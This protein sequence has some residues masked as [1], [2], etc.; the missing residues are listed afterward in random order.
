MNILG[1]KIDGHDTGAALI[2]G[3]KVIAIA[4]ER[5]MRVKHAPWTFPEKA[6]DYCLNAAGISADDLDLVVLDS[7]SKVVG[8]TWAQ[9]FHEKT[10]N[11][12]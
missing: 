9:I 5:L 1:L 8:K 7:T 2:V 3:E 11:T 4:E 6:I 12:R 10:L